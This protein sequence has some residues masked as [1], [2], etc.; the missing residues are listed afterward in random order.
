MK[1]VYHETNAAQGE[2]H[3]FLGRSIYAAQFHRLIL[4]TSSFSPEESHLITFSDLISQFYLF[5][6]FLHTLHHPQQ[7]K[8]YIFLAENL[9]ALPH[10]SK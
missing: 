3:F 8:L 7:E 9:L 6:W 2:W 4:M 1:L 10:T 5:A